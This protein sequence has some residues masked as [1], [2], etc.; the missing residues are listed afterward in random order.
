VLVGK[1]F[2][3]VTDGKTVRE[4]PFKVVTPILY[5]IGYENIV[6]SSRGRGKVLYTSRFGGYT[7]L[8]GSTEAYELSKTTQSFISSEGV[9][10]LRLV[11]RQ[12]KF[13]LDITNKP[14]HTS[15]KVIMC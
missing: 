7:S 12:V 9:F 11:E 3:S 1:V 15:K 2:S 4:W 10:T 6:K 14:K 5:R 13:V 8:L